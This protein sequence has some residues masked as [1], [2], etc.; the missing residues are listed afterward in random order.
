MPTY[1]EQQEQVRKFDHHHN[2][3]LE[4]HNERI[5]QTTQDYG[6]DLNMHDFLKAGSI[7][8]VKEQKK[9]KMLREKKYQSIGG[10]DALSRKLN[11][12]NSG[13]ESNRVFATEETLDT[14][15][16]AA[17][18]LQ[19]PGNIPLPLNNVKTKKKPRDR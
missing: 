5:K 6:I 10:D 16:N 9:R 11:K 3:Q 14:N 15:T 13:G 17:S 19:S 12:L 1:E 2:K 8:F 7:R 4:K 18:G